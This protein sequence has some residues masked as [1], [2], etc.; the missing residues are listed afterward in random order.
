[1]MDDVVP[2]RELTPMQAKGGGMEVAE[3][4]YGTLPKL[5]RIL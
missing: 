1:M 5:T 4:S 2:G 3:D